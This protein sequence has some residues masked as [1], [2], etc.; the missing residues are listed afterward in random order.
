MKSVVVGLL[1]LAAIVMWGRDALARRRVVLWDGVFWILL[2]LLG[3]AVV[4]TVDIGQSAERPLRQLRVPSGPAHDRAAMTVTFLTAQLFSDRRRPAGARGSVVV[5]GAVV[6]CY[7][8][9]RWR[10]W[11]RHRGEPPDWALARGFSTLG[12]PDNYGGYLIFPAAIAFGLR[13]ARGEQVLGIAWW[14]AFTVTV[15]ALLLCQVRGAWL[16]LLVAGIFGGAYLSGAPGPVPAR[17]PIALG[18][19]VVVLVGAG[20]L[21]ATASPTASPTCSPARARCRI[22]PAPAV[23]D[24]GAGGRGFPAPGNGSGLVP[25]RLLPARGT[26][27]EVTGG[28]RAIADDAHSLPI[29]IAA[30]LGRAGP[31]VAASLFVLVVSGPGPGFSAARREAGFDIGGAWF[32][33]VIGYTAYLFFGPSSITTSAMVALGLGVLIGVRT[34]T[35]REPS[36]AARAGRWRARYVALVTP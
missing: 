3:I 24:R 19:A 9:F 20:L 4:S 8:L 34:L 16:G 17:R 26:D 30:T 22:G 12:N 23:G 35:A 10:A 28:Y 29:M 15:A 14:A 5:G 6:A 36:R 13:S 2:A 31:L 33:A 1:V 18:L 32:A 7:G 21:V 27:Q 11:I 25:L